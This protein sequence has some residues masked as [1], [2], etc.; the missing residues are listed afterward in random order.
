VHRRTGAL[1]LRRR[2]RQPAL[3]RPQES[4]AVT[5]TR[6]SAIPSETVATEPAQAA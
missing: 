1:T 6:V 3:V 4:S 5:L 2:A